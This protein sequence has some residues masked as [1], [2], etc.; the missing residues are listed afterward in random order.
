M[1][2][3]ASHLSGLAAAVA[4]GTPVDWNHAESSASDD[5]RLAVRQLRALAEI[6][7]NR[8]MPAPGEFWSGLQLQERLG[9]GT[10]GTVFRALDPRLDRVVA[11][12]L[13]NVDALPGSG[14]VPLATMEGR[15]LARIRH[16]NVVTV[17]GADVTDAG[18]GIWME[19]IEGRTLREIVN[20]GGPLGAREAAIVGIDLCRALASIHAAGVLHRDIKAQNVIRE[21]GGRIVLMDLGAG[22]LLRAGPRTDRIVGTPAYLAP[23]VLA[24]ADH[25][26]VADIYALGVLLFFLVTGRFPAEAATI[27]ALREAHRSGRRLL[28]RDLRPD[29]PARF[30]AAVDRA[31]AVDPG[32]RPGSAGAFETLLAD[33]AES[34]VGRAGVRRRWALATAAATL[35]IAL[36]TAGASRWKPLDAAASNPAPNSMAVLPFVPDERDP[37]GQRFASGLTDELVARLGAVGGSHVVASAGPSGALT[38]DVAG[39]LGA[40][41]AVAYLF[42]GKVSIAGDRVRVLPRLVDA[43]TGATAWSQ[44]VDASGRDVLAGRAEISQQI[45][46]RLRDVLI[47]PQLAIERGAGNQ[48]RE[49]FSDYVIGRQFWSLRTAEGFSEALGRFQNAL[50]RDQRYAAALAGIADVYSLQAV[51]DPDQWDQ[52]TALALSTAQRAVA[53]SPA[54]AEAW[55]SLGYAQKNRLDFAAAEQSLQKSIALH[56]RWAPAHLWLSVVLLQQARFETAVAEAKRAHSI[57]PWSLGN[58]RQLAVTLLMSR[59]YDDAI[60]QALRVQA[61]EPGKPQPFQTLADAYIQKGDFIN[62]RA[63]VLKAQELTEPGVA[64]GPVLLSDLATVEASSGHP[65]AARKILDDLI[66]RFETHAQGNAAAV[67]SVFLAL[68]DKP[69]ALSWLRRS[70]AASE[71]EVGYLRI[72]PRWDALRGDPEFE[73]LIQ[74]ARPTNRKRGE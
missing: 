15:L 32:N 37:A 68:G 7:R 72:D 52:K 22:E 69:S 17:Y 63:A 4:D 1:S 46:A 34:S 42:E 8:A 58:N 71:S 21:R 18:V 3:E 19:C 6:S 2:T 61:L 28:L 47:G 33:A 57:D 5:D 9:V 24:G 73:R 41:L 13:F 26:V 50:R 74:S 39:R 62:A 36:L 25:S 35:A 66:R 27:A 53:L 51:Y 30:I 29:L 65:Q 55:A 56:D 64:M 40:E 11:L 48:D 70:A 12:K 38:P 67:A 45:A 10:F 44:T 20:D 60:K 16:P 31:T 23:E 54:L 59:N 49:A 43:R 14:V